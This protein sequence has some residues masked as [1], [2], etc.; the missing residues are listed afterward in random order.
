MGFLFLKL[1]PPPCALLA[2]LWRSNIFICTIKHIYIYMC[3]Y[4]C[5]YIYMYLLILIYIYIYKYIYTSCLYTVYIQ[6]FTENGGLMS[7]NKRTK[8]WNQANKEL[9]PLLLLRK[10]GSEGTPR[11]DATWWPYS[12]GQLQ[13]IDKPCALAPPVCRDLVVAAALP[14]ARSKSFTLTKCRQTKEELPPAPKHPKQRTAAKTAIG[15][16]PTWLAAKIQRTPTAAKDQR[17]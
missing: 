9:P 5:V 13:R 12:L 7:A 8:G 6:I 11:C 3:V 4:I 10:R 17:M 1:P 16:T 14:P 15:R 2:Y